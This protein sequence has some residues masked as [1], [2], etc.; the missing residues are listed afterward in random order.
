[1]SAAFCVTPDVIVDF[2]PALQNG[3]S[4]TDGVRLVNQNGVVNDTLLYDIPND[5]VLPCD[6]Q[7]VC[8]NYLC[9]PDAPEGTSLSRD[10]AHTDSDDSSEDFVSGPPTPT[11]SDGSVGGDDDDDG[12]GYIAEVCGGDDCDDLDAAVHPDA[13][14]LCD[15]KDTDCDGALGEGES[16]GDGDGYPVCAGDCDDAEAAVNPGAPEAEGNGVDDDCDG[17]T[18]EPLYGDIGPFGGSD[19][20]WSAA[21]LN[22]SIEAV[23]ALLD[24][25]VDVADRLDVAPVSF[26]EGFGVPVRAVPDPDHRIDAADLAILLQATAGYVELV[27][28]CP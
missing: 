6:G 3:G 2:V 7:A 16:D 5:N 15:G 26:C 23:L 1:M 25:G 24:L 11:N 20:L 14:E 8:P 17:Y 22:L 12:D 21:D 27:P 28:H 19:G 10:E 9:A 4:P 18:D 13:T